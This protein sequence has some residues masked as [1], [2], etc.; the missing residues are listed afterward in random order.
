MKTFPYTLGRFALRLSLALAGAAFVSCAQGGPASVGKAGSLARFA[1]R[2]DFLYALSPH[3]LTVFDVTNK[4]QPVT[5]GTVN[6]DET[7]ETIFPYGDHLYLG[8]QSGLNMYSLAIPRSPRFV[9]KYGHIVSCDPVV[10]EDGVAYV[11]LRSGG[12]CRRGVNELQIFDVRRPENPVLLAR[13]PFSSPGGLGIDTK[14]LYLMDGNEGLKILDVKNPRSLKDIGFVPMH[15]GYDVIPYG[16]LL[17]AVA[18]DGLYFFNSTRLPLTR[19]SKMEIY[20]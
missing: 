7:L 19:L 17:I 14:R 13:H 18:G 5:I 11:T 8:T 16:D 3:S 10:V 20:W 6:A 9:G 4:F 2:G 15:A 1:V 12:R